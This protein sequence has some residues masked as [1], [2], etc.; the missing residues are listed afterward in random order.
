MALRAQGF[1][2]LKEDAQLDLDKIL[3]A[4]LEAE[5]ALKA[6]K[7]NDVIEIK[8]FQKPPPLVQLTMEAVCLIFNVRLALLSLLLRPS[9]FEIK[10]DV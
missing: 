9:F 4:L 6:L 5:Q 2:L 8:T 3:P 1:L 7:K 10:S